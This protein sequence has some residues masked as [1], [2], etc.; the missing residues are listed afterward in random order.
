M[1]SLTPNPKPPKSPKEEINREGSTG[2][3]IKT[4]REFL[5]NQQN[6]IK[7]PFWGLRGPQIFFK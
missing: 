1:K 5:A 4:I 6:I 3:T 7:V 2:S